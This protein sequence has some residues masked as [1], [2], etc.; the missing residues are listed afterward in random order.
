LNQYEA[1]GAAFVGGK[2]YGDN[3]GMGEAMGTWAQN[4]SLSNYSEFA[5]GGGSV[6]SIKILPKPLP[7]Q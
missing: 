2:V 3:A 6:L 5:C 4:C 1:D 7:V